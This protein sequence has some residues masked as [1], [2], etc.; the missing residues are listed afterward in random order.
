MKYF[1]YRIQTFV[2]D[3]KIDEKYGNKEELDYERNEKI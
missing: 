3:M 1:N 2:D